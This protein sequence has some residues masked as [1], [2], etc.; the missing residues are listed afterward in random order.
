[1]KDGGLKRQ[2][3]KT[4]RHGMSRSKYFCSSDDVDIRKSSVAA[5]SCRWP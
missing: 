1:M 5:H 3:R 2:L 4:Q